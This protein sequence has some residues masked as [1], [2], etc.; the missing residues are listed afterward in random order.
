[1]CHT[2][3]FLFRDVAHVLVESITQIQNDVMSPFAGVALFNVPVFESF[4]TA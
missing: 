3:Q 1:M 4:L 2:A